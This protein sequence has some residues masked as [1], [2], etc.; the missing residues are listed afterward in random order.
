M[1]RVRSLP[2]HDLICLATLA[3]MLSACGS[4][5]SSDS[6][7]N[8]APAT[9]SLSVRVT[10]A[11][12][13]SAEHVWI[14][15]RGLQIHAAS[16]MTHVFYYC[17]D[18]ANPGQII[19]STSTC[20][21]QPAPKQLDLL[22]LTNG[23]TEFLLQDQEL[24]AGRYDWIRLM[25]DT[26]G[27]R[28]S[29]IVLQGGAEFELTIPSGNQTGLKLNRGFTVPA[30]GSA[31]FTIDFNLRQSIHKPQSPNHDYVLRPTLRLVNNV[32]VGSIAGTV[33]AALITAGCTPAV[34]VFP[35]H[36]V[37]PDDI[38][39]IAPEPVATAMVRLDNNTGIYKY[40]AAFL[41]AGDYTVSFTCDAGADDPGTDDA[42]DFTGT[43]NVSVTAGAVT[44]KNF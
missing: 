15:F 6:S 42:L 12:V 25:V 2:V 3:I 24:A 33:N 14:Q 5:S 8:T 27:L 35:G 38:D 22:A 18:P 31:D 44:T 19:V 16:G 28:D 7:V 10:D 39:G 41:E 43:A 26:E 36:G 21:T 34:Y 20:T 23:L 29:Y 32:E 11:P 9:G 40:K 1:I 37:S 13:D 4:G 17:E 30:G